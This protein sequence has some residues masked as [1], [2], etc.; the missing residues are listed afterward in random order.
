M[1][2]LRQPLIYRFFDALASGNATR[3]FRIADDIQQRA[4]ERFDGIVDSRREEVSVHRDAYDEECRNG[5]VGTE[6]RGK[7]KKS[8]KN[9]VKEKWHELCEDC[10]GFVH[11][12]S[13]K[14]ADAIRDAL[15]ASIQTAGGTPSSRQNQNLLKFLRRASRFSDNLNDAAGVRAIADHFLYATRI[16]AD[17]RAAVQRGGTVRA[18]WDLL[19]A[20]GEDASAWFALAV[21][22]FVIENYWCPVGGSVDVDVDG[23]VRDMVQLRN[24]PAFV[25]GL[26]CAF[27]MYGGAPATAAP[28]PEGGAVCWQSVCYILANLVALEVNAPTGTEKE[29]SDSSDSEEEER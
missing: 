29:G 14:H 21:T 20:R 22:E 25:S 27:E 24:W 26:R 6:P 17:L 8:F 5:T 15:D 4:K 2:Q 28:R 1:S 19:A 18:E 9:Y 10:K 16:M 11:G 3:D 13:N 12:V 7:G 23:E